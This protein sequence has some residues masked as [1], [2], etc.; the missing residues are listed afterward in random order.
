MRKERR[1]MNFGE[2]GEEEKNRKPDRA[3]PRKKSA[4]LFQKLGCAQTGFQDALK[5]RRGYAANHLRRL[6]ASRKTRG[7]KEKE[8][9]EKEKEEQEETGVEKASSP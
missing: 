8:E 4:F 2:R 7:R 1:E 6:H 3:G 9:E 5:W